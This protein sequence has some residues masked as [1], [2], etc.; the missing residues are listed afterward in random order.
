MS[1]LYAM[2][3]L[4]PIFAGTG[5]QGQPFHSPEKLILQDGI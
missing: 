2:G 4:K 5:R 3:L 1:Y